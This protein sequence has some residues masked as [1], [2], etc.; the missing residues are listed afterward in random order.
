MKFADDTNL[1]V[2]ENTKCNM[3]EFEHINNWAS[4]GGPKGGA[5]VRRRL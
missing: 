1:P 5:T 3:L 4:R 2:P